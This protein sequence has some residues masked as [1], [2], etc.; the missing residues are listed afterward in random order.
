MVPISTNAV[1]ETITAFVVCDIIDLVPKIY[2]R[3]EWMRLDTPKDMK[4]YLRELLAQPQLQLFLKSCNASF[5]YMP[6]IVI[7]STCGV[8]VGALSYGQ[9]LIEVSSWMLEDSNSLASTL[10]HEF[11]HVIKSKCRLSGSP[12]GSNWVKCLK[13]ISPVTW[14]IDKHWIPTES[15]EKKRLEI[16]PRAKRLC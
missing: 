1:T 13:A 15:I 7:K 9:S 6:T 10:R 11:A 12:H 4:D 5:I 3:V 14:E 8:R 16:H 2:R